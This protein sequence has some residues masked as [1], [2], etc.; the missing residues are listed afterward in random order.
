M[1][2][3]KKPKATKSTCRPKMARSMEPRLQR[4][5]VK[6]K[7]GGEKVRRESLSLAGRAAFRLLGVAC[8]AA[9]VT[10]GLLAG[11][12][13]LACN[14]R[15]RVQKAEVTGTE[16]LS[17]WAVLK[18]AGV[19]SQDNLISL[20]VGKIQHRV[21]SLPWVQEA[22]VSRGFPGTVRIAIKER[23]AFALALVDG[24]LFFLD[25]G[26]KASTPVRGRSIPDR[27]VITGLGMADMK[28][29]DAEILSLFGRA[30]EVT[31]LVSRTGTKNLSEIHLDRVWGVELVFND[32]PAVVRMGFT[33]FGPRLSRLAKI[34][35]DLAERGELDRALIIDLLAEHKAVVRLGEETA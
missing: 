34:K 2:K 26:M 31:E 21:S 14:P 5:K 19:G 22:D 11:Y 33:G 30:G 12:T 35:K 4:Q 28:N 15:F 6:R 24:R 16:H 7:P 29:P 3:S 20:S 25:R 8:L 9:L 18:A 27:P 32:M 13:A 10:V 1:F 23:K 17:R